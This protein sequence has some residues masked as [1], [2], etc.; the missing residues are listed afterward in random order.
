MRKNPLCRAV[1]GGAESTVA[2]LRHILISPGGLEGDSPGQ[3]GGQEEP[4][5]RKCGRGPGLSA[6]SACPKSSLRLLCCH[7]VSGGAQVAAIQECIAG[8]MDQ[9]REILVPKEPEGVDRSQP[10]NHHTISEREMVEICRTTQMAQ[11]PT[12][13]QMQ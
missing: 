10:S 5:S 2:S 8:V 9:A 3:E 7:S 11:L 1:Q 6:D 4:E 13:S 12:H